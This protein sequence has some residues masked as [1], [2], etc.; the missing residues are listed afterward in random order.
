MIIARIM[1]RNR[2]DD[3]LKL[4]FVVV[5]VVRV[6]VWACGSVGVGSLRCADERDHVANGQFYGLLQGNAFS[7]YAGESVAAAR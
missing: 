7:W 3:V 1:I 6:C 4:M 5:F 2:A